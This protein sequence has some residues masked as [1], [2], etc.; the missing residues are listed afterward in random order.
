[1]INRLLLALVMSGILLVVY[2]AVAVVATKLRLPVEAVEAAL[3]AVLIAWLAMLFWIRR[4]STS[5]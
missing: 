5:N 4:R 1:M 3:L 2:F